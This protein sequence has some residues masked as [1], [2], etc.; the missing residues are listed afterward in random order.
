MLGMCFNEIWTVESYWNWPDTLSNHIG[1]E[2][3]E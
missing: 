1:E 2:G 3:S